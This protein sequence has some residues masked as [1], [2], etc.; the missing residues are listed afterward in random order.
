[1]AAHRDAQSR[2]CL[3][4][5]CIESHP[6]ASKPLRNSI[7]NSGCGGIKSETVDL[8]GDVTHNVKEQ[9]TLACGPSKATTPM[10]FRNAA[11]YIREVFIHEPSRNS[12]LRTNAAHRRDRR[13][14]ECQLCRF[15]QFGSAFLNAGAVASQYLIAQTGLVH[16]QGGGCRA[17]QPATQFGQSR[18]R[19]FYESPFKS[20]AHG[21]SMASR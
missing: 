19:L 20:S 21:I 11:P 6:F 12:E 5:S 1:M 16:S 15:S 17:T 14:A 18:C 13:F 9:F 10:L 3:V 8:C 7:S 4:N 2:L